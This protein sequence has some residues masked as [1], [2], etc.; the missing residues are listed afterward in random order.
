MCHPVDEESDY[1]YTNF[2]GDGEGINVQGEEDDTVDDL[3]R[4][5]VARW[6]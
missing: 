1:D 5:M 4:D 6:L 2:Y 3:P